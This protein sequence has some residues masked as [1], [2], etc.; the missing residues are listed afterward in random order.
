MDKMEKL[1]EKKK[2]KK[3]SKNEIHAKSSVLNHL[4]DTAAEMMKERLGDV[5]KATIMAD[6]PEGMEKGAELVKKI[7]G[8]MPK[9]ESSG[10]KSGMKEAGEEEAEMVAEAEGHEGEESS[11][12][13]EAGEEASKE[14]LLAEIE[15]LK[16]KIEKMS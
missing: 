2:A 10:E 14:E 16:A 8:S 9:D 6:S 12:S 5:K 3:L 7:A 11:D 4:R 15:R 13:E 1:L